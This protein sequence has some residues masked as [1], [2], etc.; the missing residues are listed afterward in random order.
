MPS[1]LLTVAQARARILAAVEPL[2]S[3]CVA[4]D[5]ALDR[6]LAADLPAAGDVPPFASAAM[7]G[8]AVHAGP[9][10]RT[11][12]VIGE[13]QA[14]VPA[15]LA[16]EADEAIRTS[17]GAAVPEGADAIVRQEQVETDGDEVTLR[18][19]VAVSDDIRLRG[20]DLAA[21]SVVLPAGTRLGAAELAA[22]VAAGACEVVCA[23]RP[24]VVIL[25][26]GTE[27]RAPGE[28]LGPGEIHNANAVT[29]RA[30]ATRVGARARPADRLADDREMIEAALSKA[31]ARA[32]VIVVSG[33]VSVGPHDHV[34][35]AL[36]A[37]GVRQ[38][39][40]GVAIQPGKPTWF[41]S[42]DGCLVYGLPGNP[43]AAFVVFTLFVAPA[44][45]ALQGANPG[46]GE[47]EEAELAVPVTRHPA[48]EQAITVRLERADGRRI[49]VPNG[50]QGS[51]LIS[52]LLGADALVMIP[53]GTGELEAGSRA[54]LIRLPR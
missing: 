47:R 3:E 37:L 30:L 1:T 43:V 9:A 14:G 13:S 20:E 22:A 39:F 15:S 4:I 27:L 45:L 12:R 5:D 17:T 54:A 10:G 24:R 35:P 41:G 49:A 32:D 7:D 11:L 18:A 19:G 21:G 36:D 23:R 42:R 53:T 50:P 6:V 33:G 51:N 31:L 52:S 16:I 40:W 48:R 29:L 44:L 34:K 8:Y 46:A 28:P 38:T 26:T 2:G 25:C